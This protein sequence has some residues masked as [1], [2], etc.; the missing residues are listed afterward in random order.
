MTPLPRLLSY[1]K[2]EE[3]TG[4]SKWAWRAWA[5]RGLL[6]VIRPPG[7]RRVYLD[8]ADIVRVL[9]EWKEQAEP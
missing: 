2:A 5:V 8:R 9:N 6:P 3:E 7:T 1:A 4:V